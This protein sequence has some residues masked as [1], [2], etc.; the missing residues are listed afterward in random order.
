MPSRASGRDR[1]ARCARSPRA[2]GGPIRPRAGFKPATRMRGLRDAEARAQVAIEDAQRRLEARARDRA[3]AL[4][5]AA[6]AWSRAPRAAPPPTS[7]ITT[8]GVP[9]RSRE[10]F[11]VPGEGDAGVVDRALLHR[12]GD[13]GAELAREAAVDARGRA[14]RARG[15]R[16]RDRGGRRRTGCGD[17]NV[18]QRRRRG[19]RVAAR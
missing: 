17:G 11:G 9:V 12:R 2:R 8:R 19:A 3:R 13:H 16:W 4:R 5:R 18:Q 15:G 1:R 14:A 7:I 6:G 10:V